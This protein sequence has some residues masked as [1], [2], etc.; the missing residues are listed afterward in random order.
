MSFC[1]SNSHLVILL[2]AAQLPDQLDPN[3][4]GTVELPGDVG[5]HVHSVGAANTD[6]ETA[7]TSAIGCS[8]V[9]P[10]ETF[11]SRII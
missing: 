7:Q 3:H 6:T 11:F 8:R 10:E 1:K 4:L 2:A 9:S 5:H